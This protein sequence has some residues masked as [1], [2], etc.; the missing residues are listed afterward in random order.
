MPADL[1]EHNVFT[2]DEYKTFQKAEAFLWDV[3]VQLHYFVG[4]AEERLSFDV[5]ARTRRAMGF[6]DDNPRRAVEHS[7]GPTFWSRRMW[8]I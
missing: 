2:Q 8:A 1:V 4:R 3:R 6:T 7:C 5:A